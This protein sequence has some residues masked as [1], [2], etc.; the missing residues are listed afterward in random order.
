[1]AT[2]PKHSYTRLFTLLVLLFLVVFSLRLGFLMLSDIDTGKQY[3]NPEVA[4]S[5]V[6]GTMYD[7]NQRIL[8]IQT[9]YWGV[10]FHL[11]AIKDLAFV[12][13][14]VAPFIGMTPNEI[15]AKAAGYTTYAQIKKEID[16]RM[17]VPLQQA[18]QEQKLTSQVSIEKRL[19]RTYPATFHAAQTIG[20]INAEQEG[21]EG[22]ELSQDTY[23]NHYPSVG[24]APT[25]YGE[26][27]TLTIDLDIQYAL[28]IQL[29]QIA[30]QHYPDYAMAL[31]LDAATGDILGMSSYPWYD[32]NKISTSSSVERK[33][34]AVN[35][36][37]EPGSVFKIFSLAAVLQL[38][39]AKTQEPFL[40]DGSYEFK[41]GSSTVTINCSSAHGEVDPVT[42]LAKSCNGAIA[43]W[44]LQTEDEDFFTLL[45]RMGFTNSYDIGLPSKARGLLNDPSSWSGRSK[46][47]ISFGQELLTTALHLCVAATALG[48][49]GSMMEPNLI[50]SRHKADSGECTYL[51]QPQVLDTIF[52][53]EVTKTIREGMHQASLPGGT[54]NKARV[55][56]IELGIKTGTA[57]ILNPET[58]SYEDGTVLASSLASVPIDNPR[59]V[60]YIA[61]GNPKGPTIWGSNIAAPAVGN[62]VRSLISQGKLFAE[63]TLVR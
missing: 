27:I 6:R 61:A 57:Q 26:N 30:D 43:H 59:Y 13:E 39:Q 11:K 54:G 36:L 40:C 37:Y 25:T 1:M 28:D 33:N 32:T 17:V 3:N 62:V 5:V 46:A 29:Q 63:D 21:L 45:R 49:S 22:L 52:S 14:V 51:R 15:Q 48:P 38:A 35:Q 2:S 31:V 50:L 9:P 7:R 12:S 10:Y 4:Q 56:G 44:A 53:S 24:N 58:N 34:H 41:A 8:A 16:D 42:M 47:T 60:I 20:F 19:G 18:L 55:E 23:L